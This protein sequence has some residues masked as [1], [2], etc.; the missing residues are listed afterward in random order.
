MNA[1]DVLREYLPVLLP[2]ILIE[3]GLALTALIHVLRHRHYKCGN[4]ALWVIVVLFVQIIGPV[5][6]FVFGREES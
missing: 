4:R 6:Y 3:L 5:A 1:F 2:L